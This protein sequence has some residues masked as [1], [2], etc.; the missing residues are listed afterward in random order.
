[1]K[2]VKIEVKVSKLEKVNEW[3]KKYKLRHKEYEVIHQIGY[4][5]ENDVRTWRAVMPND[6]C[7]TI[8]SR[9]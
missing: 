8:L 5:Q 2:E 9:T 4:L 3:I 1:M 6:I 7:G